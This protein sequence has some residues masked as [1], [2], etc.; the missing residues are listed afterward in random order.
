MGADANKRKGRQKE[1]KLTLD[2]DAADLLL[3][4]A[5]SPRKQ[6]EY[7]S[8]LVRQ[9]AHGTPL[10]QSAGSRLDV[11]SLRLQMLGLSSELQMIARMLAEAEQE[12]DEHV[13]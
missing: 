5:G 8:K 4:L 12:R 11:E 2:A 13:R 3:E 1:V 9:A 6:G 7:V 10:S